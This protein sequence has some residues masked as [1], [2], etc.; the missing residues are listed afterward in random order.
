MLSTISSC[1][2]YYFSTNCTRHQPLTPS[3][4]SNR[5]FDKFDSPPIDARLLLLHHFITPHLT[6]SPISRRYAFIESIN[7]IIVGRTSP[8]NASINNATS[9]AAMLQ[10]PT[11][12]YEIVFPP[13]SG[14][15]K[16]S[17]SL[18]S[19]PIKPHLSSQFRSPLLNCFCQG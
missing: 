3:P 12:C 6:Q 13:Q 10:T 15:F 4:I 11:F 16:P 7:M 5:C 18:R 17:F 2:I 14:I 8:P 9:N 19:I 1:Y